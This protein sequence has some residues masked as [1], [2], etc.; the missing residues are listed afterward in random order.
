MLLKNALPRRIQ[1]KQNLPLMSIATQ[2]LHP[3]NYR[4]HNTLRHHFQSMQRYR[5]IENQN[6]VIQ[7]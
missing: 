4:Q 1:I 2:T 7:F 6:S 5:R 3:S